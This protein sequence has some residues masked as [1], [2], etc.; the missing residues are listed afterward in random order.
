VLER[1]DRSADIGF[2]TLFSQC[3]A[4]IDAN[5][6]IGPR[7]HLGL[8]H[9]QPDVLLGAGVHV[10]SGGRTHNFDDPDTPIRDQAGDRTL[11]TIGRGGWIGSGAIVMADVGAGTIIGAGSVVTKPLPANSIAA[12]VPARVLR[13][14]S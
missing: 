8:V 14:R 4:K 9:L 7:C 12:G 3:G 6:Y 2:G 13:D 11:V 1:C 10:T 5:V